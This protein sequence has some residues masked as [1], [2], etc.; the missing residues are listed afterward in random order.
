MKVPANVSTIVCAVLAASA[1]LLCSAQTS[2]SIADLGTIDTNGYSVAKGVN[3][4]G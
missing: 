3:I 4:A 2:Y 1:S